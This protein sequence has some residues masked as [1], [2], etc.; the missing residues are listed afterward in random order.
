MGPLTSRRSLL[1]A[2]GLTCASLPLLRLSEAH[3]AP[4]VAPLRLILLHS[5]FQV[6]EPFYHPQVS[7]SDPSL[8]PDGTNFY[9]GFPNSIL[10]P[11]APFQ[12]D[13]I[14]FRGLAY[15]G[16]I[17]SHTSGSTVFTGAQSNSSTMISDS[18]G[19]P[20][21]TESSIDNY[22]FGRM[23]QASSLSP[24]LAG[25]FTYI[26]GDHCYDADVIYSAGNPTAMVGNPL[27]LY[28]V[29]F[30]NYTPPSTQTI[31]Q[32]TINTANRRQ[33]TLGL[34]QKYLTN[35]QNALSAS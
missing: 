22:L 28:N 21:T 6:S 10:A 14:I 3:A 15:G 18:T 27:N 4:A 26:F 5:P 31:P 35:Y 29:L 7:S 33:Q 20:V 32:A 30:S 17:G 19:E 23:A 24:F 9:L 2:L 16:Q 12:S 8:A 1:K 25:F 34:V 13:L 11:L